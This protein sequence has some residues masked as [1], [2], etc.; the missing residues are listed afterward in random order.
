MPLTFNKSQTVDDCQ[1]H[2]LS[3]SASDDDLFKYTLEYYSVETHQSIFDTDIKETWD[4]ISTVHP[5]VVTALFV[6]YFYIL[7]NGKEKLDNWES[8]S[9]DLLEYLLYCIGAG[10]TLSNSNL[11]N[12][13]F[14][15]SRAIST[16][17][18]HLNSVLFYFFD[19]NIKFFFSFRSH[20][21][22]RV[23]SVYQTALIGS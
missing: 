7:G 16:E 19:E 14:N 10:S 9:S 2:S 8:N 23:P 20:K 21:E 11:P 15:L 17:R 1:Q 5:S 13:V 4:F 18:F 12:I 6:Y 22:N 3:N